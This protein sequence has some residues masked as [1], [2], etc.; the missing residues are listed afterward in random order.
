[1]ICSVL[2]FSLTPSYKIVDFIGQKTYPFSQDFLLTKWNKSI[3]VCLQSKHQ[4]Y[5]EVYLYSLLK[6]N[7]LQTFNAV[8]VR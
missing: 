8:P 4:S 3:H 1:M 6:S 2:L 5:K 7:A